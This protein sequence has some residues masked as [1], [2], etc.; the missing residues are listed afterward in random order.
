MS[1]TNIHFTMELLIENVKQYPCLWDVNNILYRD[2]ERKDLIWEM[3]ARACGLP[4]GSVARSQWKRL[5]ECHREALRRK[6]IAAERGHI[7]STCWKF[8]REMEFLI[9]PEK[10][11]NNSS[12]MSSADSGVSSNV[13]IDSPIPLPFR[14]ELI[15]KNSTVDDVIHERRDNKQTEREQMRRQAVDAN[16]FPNDGLSDLFSSLCQKTRELPKY[17]Q[18]RVQ[19]EVFES[20]TR[21]EEEALSLDQTVNMSSSRRSSTSSYEYVNPRPGSSATVQPKDEVDIEDEGMQIK[22]EP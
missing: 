3:V 15:N 10:R 8:E 22:Q 4:N 16:R 11:D 17:L 18:L 21:A 19:R 7:R 12:N 9:P 20:V 1:N 14:V 6:K 2:S 5:R 13:K